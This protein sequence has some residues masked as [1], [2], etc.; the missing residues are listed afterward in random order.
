MVSELI[1]PFL[2]KLLRLKSIEAAAHFLVEEALDRN[3]KDN[4]T[5]AIVQMGWSIPVASGAGA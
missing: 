2:G 3:S 4:V 5:V 1:S